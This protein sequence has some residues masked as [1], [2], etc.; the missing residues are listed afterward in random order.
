MSCQTAG[1]YIQG[2]ASRPQIQGNKIR[3][4]RCSAIVTALDVDAYIVQNE[5]QICGVGIE[6][7]NN[8]SKLF[9][10]Q[11]QKSHEYGIQIVGDDN[12]TRSMPLIWR[13]KI[14]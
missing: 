11:I 14:E 9:D 12:R 8:K 10:N 6:I 2:E 7:Q 3:F 4:C 1:V 5:I 13:N